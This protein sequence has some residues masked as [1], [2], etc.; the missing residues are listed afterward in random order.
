MRRIAR[1]IIYLLGILSLFASSAFG[2]VYTAVTGTIT[3]PNGLPYSGASINVQLAPTPPGPSNC[4]TST[5]QT[6]G[7]TTANAA[8]FFQI[9]L[10][11]NASITPAGSQ[12][13]FNVSIS[14]GII[15]PAG[16]GPQ[17][18][19]P[20]LITIAGAS[21]SV[22]T[23]ISANCPALSNITSGS[24]GLIVVTTLPGTCTPG[25]QYLLPSGS[26]V[27]CGP[28][29]NQF[30]YGVPNVLQATSFGVSGIG[31]NVNDITT[32]NGLATVSSAAQ[33]KWCN[34]GSVPC[35]NGQ[36][37][38]VGMTMVV[39]KTCVVNAKG[40]DGEIVGTTS[41]NPTILSVQSA[42]SVTLSQNANFSAPGN[43]CADYGPLEDTAM[44]AI[45]TF[46]GNLTFGCPS[47]EFPS[48]RML[49]AAPHIYTNPIP[50]QN[51][52]YPAALGV[53]GGGLDVHGHGRGV[54]FFVPLPAFNW[55][56]C[57]HGLTAHSCFGGIPWSEWHDLAITGD[58][59]S[60][61]NTTTSNAIGLELTS[62]M[63]LRHAQLWNW[64]M[65]NS[66]FT[67]LYARAQSACCYAQ[68]DDVEQDG[69]G[70]LG[71]NVP[72]S[73]NLRASG[74]NLQDNIGPGTDNAATI[75]GTLTLEGQF[76]FM[77]WSNSPTCASGQA[78]LDISG[79]VYGALAIQASATSGCYVIRMES[80][81]SLRLAIPS[82]ATWNGAGASPIYFAPSSTGAFVSLQ[83]TTLS[84]TGGATACGVGASATGNTLVD[85]GGNVGIDSSCNQAGLTLLQEANSA[86]QT[87][88]TAAKI[89]LS[90]GWG[91]TATVTALFGANAPIGFTITNS[92]TG[93]AA[94]PSFALTFPT[95]YPIA[96]LSCTA[97][98][99][100]GTNPLLNPFTTSALSATGATFTATGTPTVSDTENMQI[101]CVTQ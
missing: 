30:I 95:P 35:P 47:I 57:T 58:G 36:P 81:G 31:T 56:G 12:W 89:V 51:S 94:T 23:S 85:A 9:A 39:W 27:T 50:C 92:G 24:A 88:V 62:G 100:S 42:L 54:T 25:A 86:N 74:Y 17:V 73:T 10:C 14:P 1:S 67:G 2:Q 53:V 13:Q 49:V 55:A 75:A 5:L 28:L 87:P 26:V 99:L 29:A 40:T 3:D 59:Q 7:H 60:T 37:T 72:A 64:G 68:I 6:L 44:T 79:Q 41:A 96:P 19:T 4:G 69:F 15:P 45:D 71:L 82:F 97:T 70:G 32:T 76:N 77:Q 52:G 43:A 98:D 22:S 38:S 48:A 63:I 34:A 16:T 78:L 33:A 20:T 46:L 93:Q 21:Q 80:G 61:T 65:Y 90:A 8:G 91:S 84:H 11:P 101:T 83:G 66:D 18:C